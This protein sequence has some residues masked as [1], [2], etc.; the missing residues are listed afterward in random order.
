MQEQTCLHVI[1][2]RYEKV[3]LVARLFYVWNLLIYQ[4]VDPPE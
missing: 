1:S 3:G 4:I 2:V